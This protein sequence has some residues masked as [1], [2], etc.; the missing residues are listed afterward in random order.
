MRWIMT[1]DCMALKIE[2]GIARIALSRLPATWDE[3]CAFASD[4]EEA[5]DAMSYGSGVNV[6]LLEG[7]RIEA[8]RMTDELVEAFWAN[9]RK[10]DG[11]QPSITRALA[12]INLPIVGVFD[13]P[14][15]G[16]GLELALCC[17][18]RLSSDSA[19][20]GL[21]HINFGL[22]PWE[23]GTQRLTRMVGLPKALELILLGDTI[24]AREAQRT[25]LVHRVLSTDELS[26]SAME[27]A[28]DMAQKS[29]LSM[30]YSKEAI[31]SGMDLSLAQG[32]RMEADLY[33]LM[34]SSIDRTE[35]IRAFQEKR[36]PKFT[37][38]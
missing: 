36:K 8:F 25:G 19:T 32:L 9:H 38:K 26:K 28:L 29:P 18:V 21:P 24:S 16:I 37:G 10:S 6:V 33:F 4:L 5:T 23:G 12:Q 35:G 20:Y 7:V 31:I 15:T 3:V 30:S 22:I 1:S 14:V 27:L 17:D 13:G 11:L 34:H 2:D